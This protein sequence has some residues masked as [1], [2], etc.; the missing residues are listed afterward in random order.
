MVKLLHYNIK[1]HPNPLHLTFETL[2]YFVNVRDIIQ[3]IRYNFKIYH[4]KIMVYN[5]GGATLK[6]KDPV[7][8]GKTYIIK[9]APPKRIRLLLYK[10]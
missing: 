5:E 10:E 6:D 4:R 3:T 7:E 9:C 2:R 8:N 1:F